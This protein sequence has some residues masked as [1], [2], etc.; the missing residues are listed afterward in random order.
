M[1]F[2]NHRN[3]I[4]FFFSCILLF[5]ACNKNDKNNKTEE[6]E[7]TFFNDTILSQQENPLLTQ[8]RAYVLALDSADLNSITLAIDEY[9]VLFSGK[10][11]GLCDTSFVALQDLLDSVE[12]NLNRQ[13]QNDTVD[14]AEVLS[15][16]IIPQ[17]IKE[18]QSNLQK[19]GFR[20]IDADGFVYIEQQRKF[21]L[22]HL[23]S[24]LSEPLVEYLTEID[25]ETTEGFA[26]EE[27]ISIPAQKLV[28]RIIWYENFIK[29]NPG[30]VLISNCKNYRKAYFTYL[31]KGYGNTFLLN[32]E[33]KEISTYFKTAYTYLSKKYPESETNA[34]VL[35]YYEKLKQKQPTSDLLKQY[36]VKGLIYNLD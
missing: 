25:T 17:N 28:D 33:T 7:T 27:K 16:S 31:L 24:F 26:K 22:N 32:E 30:F 14:Y 1:T 21:V 4:L 11:K 15:K 3:K 19:N 13:L 29:S 8:Y 36:F 18:F 34:L 35:P 10:S 6:R 23:S 12:L 2:K 20:L 5:T 9:K